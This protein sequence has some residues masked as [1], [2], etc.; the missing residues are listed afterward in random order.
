MTSD[1]TRRYLIATAAAVEIDIKPEWMPNVVRFF[2]IAQ[3]MA[4]EVIASGALTDA[5]S[6]AVFTPWEKE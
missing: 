4:A 3:G 2:E 5:E 6:A 1:E